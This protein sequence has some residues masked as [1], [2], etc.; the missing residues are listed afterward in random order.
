MPSE[1]FPRSINRILDQI[2]DEEDQRDWAAVR[3][4][5]LD[6]LLIDPEDED[7]KEFLAVARPRFEYGRLNR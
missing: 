2:E 4:G 1:K 7:A 3:L 6:L 5:A